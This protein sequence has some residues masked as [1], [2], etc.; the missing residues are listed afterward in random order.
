[1]NYNKK[2]NKDIYGWFIT[3]D[4]QKNCA[5]INS[6]EDDTWVICW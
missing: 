6:D 3:R 5:E 2:F 4:S 1:M